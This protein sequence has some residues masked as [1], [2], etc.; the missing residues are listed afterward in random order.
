ML[1]HQHTLTFGPMATWISS[2]LKTH[3]SNFRQ[4]DGSLHP[5]QDRQDREVALAATQGRGSRGRGWR[6]TCRGLL[7][8]QDEEDAAED[9][10]DQGRRLRH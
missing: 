4:S 2:H 8:V 1:A 10:P 7:R 3:S 5:S 9:G 6:P